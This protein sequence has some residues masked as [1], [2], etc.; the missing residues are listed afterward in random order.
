MTSMGRLFLALG[1]PFDYEEAFGRPSDYEKGR[2]VIV[3]LRRPLPLRFVPFL[4]LHNKVPSA[5]FPLHSRPR[6]FNPVCIVVVE[7]LDLKVAVL[8]THGILWP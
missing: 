1:R 3:G 5:Y 2:L 7:N 4:V 8:V 6:S